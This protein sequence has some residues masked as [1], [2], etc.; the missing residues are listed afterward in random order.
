MSYPVSSRKAEVLASSG[1]RQRKL[2]HKTL[3]EEGH[4]LGCPAPPHFTSSSEGAMPP[5]LRLIPAMAK[6]RTNLKWLRFP[7]SSLPVDDL[8]HCC[9]AIRVGGRGSGRLCGGLK[10]VV[11]KAVC[12]VGVFL[13]I[14]VASTNE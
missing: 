7:D 9:F 8:S 2:R 13:Q 14:S 6:D 1:T 10:A 4:W 12:E 11:E 3:G 5:G